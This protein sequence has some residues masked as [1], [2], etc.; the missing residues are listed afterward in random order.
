MEIVICVFVCWIFSLLVLWV[1]GPLISKVTVQHICKYI[2]FRISGWRFSLMF[3]VPTRGLSEESSWAAVCRFKSEIQVASVPSEASL[4]QSTF[5]V[6]FHIL[7]DPH[8]DKSKNI[9]THRGPY[10]PLTYI[11]QLQVIFRAVVVY[12]KYH[13]PIFQLHQKPCQT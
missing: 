7:R 1:Y 11:S 10:F 4:I 8:T 6:I 9:P 13:T 2:F 12:T 3:I 5:H